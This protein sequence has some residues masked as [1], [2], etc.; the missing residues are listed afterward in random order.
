MLYLYTYAYNG[1]V[2]CKCTGIAHTRRDKGQTGWPP[3]T[4]CPPETLLL[5]SSV[6]LR[7]TVS[8]GEKEQKI[9][10]RYIAHA[11][12]Y[13]IW[14][15]PFPVTGSV[16]S[17]PPVFFLSFPLLIRKFDSPTRSRRRYNNNNYYRS[18]S[19]FMTIINAAAAPTCRQLE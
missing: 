4:P 17:A 9:V 2:G 1:I 6:P 11:A 16:P 15:A 7:A 5:H 8:L 12:A 3:E 18:F 14:S 13:V 10:G 19:P